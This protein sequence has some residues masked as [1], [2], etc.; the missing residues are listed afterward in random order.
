VKNSPRYP[1]DR[2]LG[3]PHSRSRLYGEQ[4][5]LLMEPRFLGR[6]AYS[7]AIT[8]VKGKLFVVLN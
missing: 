6:R 7:P 3:G 5:H 2:R 1:L 4:K 8:Y